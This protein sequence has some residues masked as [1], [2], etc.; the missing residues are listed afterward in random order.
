MCVLVTTMPQCEC[1]CSLTAAVIPTLLTHQP[2]S[3][4]TQYGTSK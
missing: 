3:T 1:N 4:D 2:V